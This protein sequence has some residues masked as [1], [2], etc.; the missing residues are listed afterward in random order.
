MFKN[1]KTTTPKSEKQRKISYIL[2]MF[3]FEKLGSQNP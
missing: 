2:R 1:Y 3:E